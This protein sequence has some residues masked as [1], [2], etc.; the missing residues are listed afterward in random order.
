M[1]NDGSNQLPLSEDEW[2]GHPILTAF[3]GLNNLLASLFHQKF[4]FSFYKIADIFF[5]KSSIFQLM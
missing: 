5:W 4:I 2:G 1:S 3:P